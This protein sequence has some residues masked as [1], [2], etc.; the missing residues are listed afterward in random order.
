MMKH[1]GNDRF[2]SFLK[3]YDV[4]KTLPIQEKYNSSAAQYYR[5]KLNAEVNGLPGPSQLPSKHKSGGSKLSDLQTSDPLP[6]ESEA[7]YVVRQRRL[8]EEV[9]N[10]VFKLYRPLSYSACSGS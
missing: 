4:A 2:N 8:Q 5:E 9:C 1:G 3:D 7:D 6:G 10:I